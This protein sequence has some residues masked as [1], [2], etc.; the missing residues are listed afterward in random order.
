MAI[1]IVGILLIGAL[2]VIPVVAALQLRKSFT[3][4]ILYAEGISLVSVVAGIIVSFY[5]DLSTGGTIVLI[6]LTIFLAIIAAKGKIFNLS[7][8]C[9]LEQMVEMISMALGRNLPKVRVPEPVASIAAKAL[10]WIPGFPLTQSRVDALVNRSI[11]PITS[12]QQD[13]EY[14]HVVSMED[15]IRELVDVYKQLRLKRT[16]P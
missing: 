6:M 7:D 3:Q 2:I 10:G 8:Y 9:T 11:Y 16:L 1:P 4:T 14:Q 13:L 12:I 5:C 15:G